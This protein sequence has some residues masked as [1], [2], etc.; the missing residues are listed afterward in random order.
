MNGLPDIDV[1]SPPGSDDPSETYGWWS[2]A[3]E[4]LREHMDDWTHAM[5]GT[6]SHVAPAYETRE[7]EKCDR[8]EVPNGNGGVATIRS[9]WTE[10]ETVAVGEKLVHNGHYIDVEITSESERKA[11]AALAHSAGLTVKKRAGPTRFTARLEP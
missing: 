6:E 5:L 7:V 9:T 1:G 3:L 4:V 11:V 10:E 8:C 2:E